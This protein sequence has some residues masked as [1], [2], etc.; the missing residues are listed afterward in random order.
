MS[1]KKNSDEKSKEKEK[2]PPRTILDMLNEYGNTTGFTAVFRIYFYG[3]KKRWIAHIFW[4]II[5]LSFFS[6]MIYFLHN[7]KKSYDETPYSTKVQ[8]VSPPQLPYPVI[9]ICR[10]LRVGDINE[11]NFEFVNKKAA[12]KYNISWQLGYYLTTFQDDPAYLPIRTDAEVRAMEDEF[13]RLKASQPN[14]QDPNWFRDFLTEI[15]SVPC[16]D[17]FAKQ[18]MDELG[19]PTPKGTVC[20]SF[21][22]PMLTNREFCYILDLKVPVEGDNFTSILEP[23]GQVRSGIHGGLDIYLNSTA[24]TW[25]IWLAF[26]YPYM[27]LNENLLVVEKNKEIRV[28]LSAKL[29]K[30]TKVHDNCTKLQS[31]SHFPQYS[32]NTCLYECLALDILQTCSCMPIGWNISNPENARWCE[33]YDFYKCYKPKYL[34]MPPWDFKERVKNCNKQCPPLCEEWSFSKSTS[35]K[36]YGIGD[37]V[38]VRV[39]FEDLS[40]QE[41]TKVNLLTPE[42]IMGAVGGVMGFWFGASIL[43][44]LHLF[45]WIVD[46]LYVCV[47]VLFRKKTEKGTDIHLT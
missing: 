31:S 11:S 47:K 45:T 41:I 26:S 23:L 10:W 16:E 22:K 40:Y 12:A 25:G 2:S 24:E 15:T 18:M 8:E 37:A 28:A 30:R 39:Y 13:Q 14:S 43:S 44:L 6:T 20:G 1:E 21:A 42:G 33:P 34:E 32:H 46:F 27:P 7:L 3:I 9:A 4:W 19:T 17:F 38:R 5:A 35:V 36:P 29:T